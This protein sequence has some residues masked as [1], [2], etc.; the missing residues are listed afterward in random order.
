[1][2]IANP[3]HAPYGRA[4]EAAPRTKSTT[5][6]REICP[7]RKHLPGRAVRAAAT[8]KSAFSPCPWR[9]DRT[10]ARSGSYVEIPASAHPPIEQ[11]A[12][13]M[14]AST[15]RVA[16]ERFLAYLKGPQAQATFRK[17]APAQRS[18]GA[19]S[20]IAD[21]LAGHLAHRQARCD[22]LGDSAL[23]QSSTRPLAHVLTATLELSARV[24]RV[25]AARAAAHRARVL[26]A[27]G[28]GH[29]KP[30]RPLPG[31]R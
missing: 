1:M 26:S 30:D 31:R 12:I 7:W 28:D 25:A 14:K 8:P 19:G 17:Y 2:A 29:A 5:P 4:A 3:E 18:D 13:I 6:C 21:G 23:R 16:A 15:N 10:D 27:D 20:A 9:W 22:R 11:G 24:D